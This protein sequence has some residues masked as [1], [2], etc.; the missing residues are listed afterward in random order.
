MHHSMTLANLLSAI[1]V[2]AGAAADLMIKDLAIDSRRVCPGALF[3]AYPGEAADGRAYIDA[4]VQAGASAILCEAVGF[5]APEVLEV[6]GA[7]S[8]PLLMVT[9]L[10]LKVGLLA[11]RFFGAPSQALQIFG[12]TG[13]NGKTT[14]CYLLTQALMELGLEAAMIGTIGSGRLADM[15]ANSHTTPN[16][17]AIHRTLATWREQGVTQVCMEVSSHALDQGRVAGIQFFCTL[18][19]N[20]SHDHLDYH[21]DMDHYAAAKLKLFTEYPS[22]LVITNAEDQLGARLIEVADGQFIAS[23]GDSGDVT[24]EDV[25]LTTAGMMLNIVAKGVEF[26]V[27]TALL[28]RVN[29]ANILLVVTTL[30]SLSTSIKDIQRVIAKLKPAP[31]RMEQYFYPPRPHV[32]IDYAHTPDALEKALLSLREHCLG[33]LWCV[34]GCGGERDKAKR[35]L[36]GATADQY[37]DHIVITNDNPRSEAG[38]TIAEDILSAICG[39]AIVVLDRA[40]AIRIAIEQATSDDW[41][42]VAGKGHETT[43]QI[44]MDYLPFSDREQVAQILGVAV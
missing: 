13:T 24:A 4:A 29:I 2:D 33:R 18:F 42:L 38:Q 21:G 39:D 27:Q 6:P 17:V 5:E 28:G 7:P 34:F 8:V 15:S 31:G 40:K 25:T 36:M 16:P 19:T 32:V 37:A 22:E 9:E 44:G 30:L 1:S 26:E 35:A 20:L 14:S 10:Q 43:Q 41:V 23:Y 3:C 11:D 12:V